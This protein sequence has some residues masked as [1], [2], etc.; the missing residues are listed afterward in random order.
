MK[1]QK[2][3]SQIISKVVLDL[4]SVAASCNAKGCLELD[5][6]EYTK[7]NSLQSSKTRSSMLD[8]ALRGDE[9]VYWVGIGQ[10]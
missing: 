6:L 9:A 7:K 10:Q 2:K 8:C 3:C 1:K 5:G 4:I